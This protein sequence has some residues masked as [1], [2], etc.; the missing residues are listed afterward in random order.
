MFIFIDLLSLLRFFFTVD[1]IEEVILYALLSRLGGKFVRCIA[2]LSFIYITDCN[3]N[4]FPIPS[5]LFSFW[6]FH[7]S[8]IFNYSAR[9]VS[10][11]IL[12]AMLYIFGVSLYMQ[13]G[14]FHSARY[15]Y[16]N[17]EFLIIA[18]TLI[19]NYMLQ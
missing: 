17:I 12:I 2:L 13:G 10:F 5:L 16:L 8:G 1:G 3:S 15:V 19:R 14:A 11:E 6:I 9:N 4:H 18:S 7:A